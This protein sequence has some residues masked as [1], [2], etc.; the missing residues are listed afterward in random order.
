[1]PKG[2]I[3]SSIRNKNRSIDAKLEI[4]VSGCISGFFFQIKVYAS[5]PTNVLSDQPVWDDPLTPCTQLNLC[6]TLL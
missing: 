6:Q 5:H 2:I 4:C 1:M 3:L